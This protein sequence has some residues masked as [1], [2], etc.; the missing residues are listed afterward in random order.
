VQACSSYMT[1][2][3]ATP[4]A[5][6]TLLAGWRARTAP[7]II[8]GYLPPLSGESCQRSLDRHRARESPRGHYQKDDDDD[9]TLLPYVDGSPGAAVV[10]EP[11]HERRHPRRQTEARAAFVPS[12]ARPPRRRLSADNPAA[13]ARPLSPAPRAGTQGQQAG[14]EK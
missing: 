6:S 10:R 9:V 5:L 13:P 4:F 3:R 1:T 12:L 14:V 11:A 8:S 2:T 7:S